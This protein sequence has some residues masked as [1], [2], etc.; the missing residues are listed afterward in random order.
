M[1]KPDSR[2]TTGDQ[3]LPVCC[4]CGLLS[5]EAGPWTDERWVTKQTFRNT[6]GIDPAACR[7]SHTYCPA[8]YTLFL[9]RISA[10]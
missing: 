1:H 2:V 8:C 9:N 3:I 7:L 4:G 6:H 5:D 10:A